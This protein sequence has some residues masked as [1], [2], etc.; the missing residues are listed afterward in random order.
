M[1]RI[2]IMDF[3]IIDFHT[4]PFIEPASNV[5]RYKNYIQNI[6]AQDTMDDLK[7]LGVS[8]ICGSVVLPFDKTNYDWSSVKRLNEIAL[9][10]SDFYGDF[11]VPGFHVHPSYI[12]ESCE[13]IEAMHKR[14]IKLIGEVVPYMHGWSG[15]GTKELAEILDV[16]QQYDMIFNLHTMDEEGIDKLLKNHPKLTVV[17]AHPG[18]TE[19]FNRHLERMKNHKNYYLDLSGSGMFRHASMRNAIDTVGVERF[20]YGSDYPVCNPGMLL[21]G[22]VLDYTLTDEEKEFLLSKNAKRLLNLK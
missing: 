16:A 15:Y 3:E 22:V 1:Q 11:Y 8:K 2:L 6:T 20:L 7:K 17:A 13:E 18:E 4:H 14:G 12:K 19:M 10:L 9:E 21:G 5:C